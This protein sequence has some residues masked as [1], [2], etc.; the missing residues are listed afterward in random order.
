M[1]G[2]PRIR[3]SARRASRAWAA[4][5]L[6]AAALTLLACAPKGTESGDSGAPH[7]PNG[8]P[9]EPDAAVASAPSGD[10]DE[11]DPA[12]SAENELVAPPLPTETI[13]GGPY[14]FDGVGHALR[15]VRDRVASSPAPEGAEPLAT[16]QLQ[17]RAALIGHLAV[18]YRQPDVLDLGVVVLG[19]E[20]FDG[21]RRDEITYF[22]EPLVRTRAF[23]YVPEGGGRRP[24]VVFWHGH[25][26]GGHHASGGVEPYA[27]TNENDGARVLAEAGF[28]VLAPTLRSFHADRT[29]HAVFARVVGSL[30]EVSPSA[31]YVTDALR[32]T[33]VLLVRDDVDPARVGMTGVSLGGYV[34]LLT[35][36]LDTRISAASVHAFYPSTSGSFTRS[37]H[38]P[39]PYDRFV[40]G[41][42]D[43]PD[44]G[45]LV[46]PRHLQVVAGEADA[47]FPFDEQQAGF[48]ATRLR[49]VALGAGDSATFEAHE[50]G[51]AWV[52]A[53]AVPWFRSAFGGP[54]VGRP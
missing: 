9:A 51:H 23:L 25:N 32:A 35:A 45:A 6:L 48:A 49:F 46:A 11:R 21:Y 54:A 13:P 22:V 41:L 47:E 8:D 3:S 50:G 4:R 33:D 7:T 38:C 30:G 18:R 14:T 12:P 19:S 16:W 20:R 29:A 27:N 53:L 15:E 5:A 44:L 17:T 31:S 42:V 10:T 28:V 1:T 34:T 39:C 2:T 43:V 40:F 36:S 26:V 37:L 52:G 24:A